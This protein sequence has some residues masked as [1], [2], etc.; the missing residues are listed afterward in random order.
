M[1]VEFRATLFPESAKS[2]DANLAAS[3]LLFEILKSAS[4]D[5][6][7]HFQTGLR[8]GE[9]V[10]LRGRPPESFQGKLGPATGEE[11]LL[12]I[13]GKVLKLEKNPS[14]I[15]PAAIEELAGSDFALSVNSR[16]A[17]FS[18]SGSIEHLVRKS[19]SGPLG[20]M[21][22][23][24][25]EEFLFLMPLWVQRLRIGI[26]IYEKKFFGFSLGSAPQIVRRLFLDAG[27]TAITLFAADEL[28]EDA[29]S[30]PFK[31]TRELDVIIAALDHTGITNA[32]QVEVHRRLA[33]STAA[34]I[35]FEHNISS[36]Q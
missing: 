1:S 26:E 5:N 27:P 3:R 12:H 35:Q 25:A 16:F 10:N 19:L 11:E 22:S 13:S 15:N 14:P 20:S 9:V 29:A 32:L 18:P 6:M 7:I 4:I 33:A 34:N 28:A 17:K 8:S 30:L 21:P 36:Q 31:K 2:S 24:G 23:A